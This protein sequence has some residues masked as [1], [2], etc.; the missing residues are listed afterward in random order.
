MA[1]KFLWV[2]L[3]VTVALARSSFS[4]LPLEVANKTPDTR[5][6][7]RDLQVLENAL[8]ALRLMQEE[9]FEPWLGTWP[10]A[11][12]WTAA[13]MGSHVSGTLSSIS[14]GLELLTDDDD[15]GA[16]ENLV[17]LYFS[18]VLG[19]Y[20]GQD[21]FAIR[22]EAFDD[23]LWVVLQW[24]DAITFIDLHTDLHYPTDSVQARPSQSVGA[25]LG[26]QTWHGNVWVPAFAHRA[27][28]FW[29]LASKGWDTTLCGG[30]MIWNPR[31][32]PYKNAITN[33]LFIA[34]S[35]SMYLFF[36]G[37]SNDS[38]FNDPR[39]TGA[40]RPH[41]PKYLAAAVAG[42][43]WLSSSGMTNRQGL[44]VDG[45]HI[46][47]RHNAS[48]PNTKCDARSEM[49]FTY[50]QGVILSGQV[51]L[52]Q[53][54]GDFSFLEDGHRLI[55]SVIAATGYDLV[56][57]RAV[58]DPT[59]FWPG[60]L[61]PWRGLGRAGVL[62]EI[63]DVS[64]SCSQDTQTFKGIF[65]HHMS[66]FCAPLDPILG[67]SPRMD[68]SRLNELRV[69]HA[70]AC[71]RYSGWLRHNAMAALLTKDEKGRF[72]MWWTAGLLTQA[73]KA[74]QT[75]EDIAPHGI[76]SFDYRTYGVPDHELWVSLPRG[77]APDER[78]RKR[79]HSRERDAMQRPLVDP[80][81]DSSRHRAEADANAASSDP[82]NR[83]RGRTV[84]TQG[85]GLAL[86]RALWEVSRLDYE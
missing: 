79:R 47:G 5:S 54:T 7:A 86:L 37:D 16:K 23:M 20:F 60:R 46:S 56:G 73:S 81:G 31:L 64:G 40:T 10:S 75:E 33:E 35:V 32:E 19:S 9:Y 27:R 12:D 74:T 58:D 50:N 70:A 71:Q 22:G 21:A 52:W 57:D 8:D 18:E 26:N 36:P 72:G 80:N 85:G 83:G 44:Y 59:V 4:F 55:Q 49:V 68:S 15:C 48:H 63:C 24:L 13:V 76:A 42:Y 34:A 65:F 69:A 77:R 2:A 43:N 51:R 78:L 38:P 28:I 11:I 67:V 17:T 84:E 61:P 66:A 62:E 14:Q 82:N 29:E 30:G 41:D 3:F 39:K 6:A 25:I 45:F 53:A 1:L